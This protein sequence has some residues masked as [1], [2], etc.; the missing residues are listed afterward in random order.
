MPGDVTLGAVRLFVALV[1]AAV[2]VALVTRRT[3]L[4]YTVGLVLVGLAIALLRPGV[5]LA[6]TPE[7]VLAVLLP[8]LIFE[9]AFRTPF[10]DLRPSLVGVLL[11]A[12][13][14]VLIVAVV[15][16]VALSVGSGMRLELAFLVGAMVAATDPAAVIATFKRLHAPRRLV[17]IVETESLLND[18]TGIVVFALA[19]QLIRGGGSIE[20]AAITFLVTVVA[21]GALGA[22]AGFVAARLVRVVDDHVL[23]LAISL[24]L[25]YGSY[26]VAEGIHLSGIIATVL[27]AGTFGTIARRDALSARAIASI[28]V[29][30][31]FLAF[32]LT[33]LVFLL[34]GVSITGEDLF[35]AL[36]PIAW[37]VAAILAA[38][39]I[40]VYGLLGITSQVAAR[41]A[42]QRA[43]PVAWLHVVFWAGLRGAVSVALALSLPT[44]LP[45]RRLL[46]DVTFGIVLFTLL[47]QGS[48]AGLVV[49]RSGAATSHE[50]TG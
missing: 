36:Q 47:V 16:A 38:R 30:W 19:L 29:V 4:P 2:V 50:D 28:D 39:A 18:G 11:L 35:G 5:E 12:V 49:R 14:G 33:A 15:V 17:A 31:E 23:E 48:T 42:D 24:V 8:G 7:L 34:V 10:E 44:D 20:G 13:P 26:L 43:I 27:A 3:A 32:L 9:A 21:S 1:A 22:A 40:V 37:G 46:Q 6:I 41:V 25:A 45:D